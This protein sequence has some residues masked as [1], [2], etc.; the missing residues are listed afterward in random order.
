MITRGLADR[1]WPGEEALGRSLM[2]TLSKRAKQ[3]A[4]VIGVVGNVSSSRATEDW[5]QIFVPLLQHFDRPRFKIV[6]RGAGDV[7][8]LTRSIRSAIWSIDPLFPFS[9]VV[10]SEYLV[11]QSTQP[12][13]VMAQAA[14]GFGLL[15]L[16]LS[17]IG[18]YG[19][20]AFMVANRTREIGLRMAI[21][22]TRAQ[23]LR[24]VMWDAI[25]LAAPGLAVGGLLA[26]G[27]EMVM[28]SMLLGVG[29]LDP[30]S[31]FAATGV[32]IL[33]VLLASLVPA[34]RAAAIDPMDAL[35]YQ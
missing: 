13:R 17:A 1:L 4:T 19:V 7:A 20:V 23:V 32:L 24:A 33:V 16:L 10:T 12:Q 9:T 25:R 11:R 30:V 14:G 18:V 8:T 28:G 26:V 34:L 27:L 5:P 2:V 35:R 22:A 21:G 3:P 15:T 6:V 31:L 29:P